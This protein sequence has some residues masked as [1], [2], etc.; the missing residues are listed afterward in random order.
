MSELK[1]DI[2][3]WRRRIGWL[4]LWR[5]KAYRYT[6]LDNGQLVRTKTVGPFW[7]RSSAVEAAHNEGVSIIGPTLPVPH[8]DVISDKHEVNDQKF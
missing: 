7:R 2:V 4:P 8:G 1:S 3:I 5:W 6:R